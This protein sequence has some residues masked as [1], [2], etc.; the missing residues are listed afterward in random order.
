MKKLTDAVHKGEEPRD[1]LIMTLAMPRLDLNRFSYFTDKF[2][3]LFYFNLVKYTDDETFFSSL[4]EI[5]KSVK[6][7]TDY[8]KEEERQ[9]KK[10]KKTKEKL[11]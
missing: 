11:D 2:T 10:I 9:F 3:F 8:F 4:H 5:P 1:F 7:I 6:T